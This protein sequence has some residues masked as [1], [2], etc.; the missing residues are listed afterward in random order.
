MATVAYNFK[1]IAALPAPTPPRRQQE[2]GVEGQIGLLVVTS[3]TGSKDFYLRCQVNGRRRKRKL[4]TF[5]DMG[6]KAAGDAAVLL[7]AK[8]GEGVVPVGGVQE[9]VGTYGELCEVYLQNRATGKDRLGERTLAE[10]RRILGLPELTDLRSMRPANVRS[11]D[12]A[13]AL[14]AFEE[15]DALVML[16]AVQLAISAVFTWGVV[17]HRYGLEVNPVATM[18]SR[19]EEVPRDRVL[20][21]EEMGVMWLDLEDR[22]PLFRVALRLI[23]LTG[24]RPGEVRRMRWEDIDG[25]TWT[26]PAGYRKRTKADRGRPSKAHRVHLSAPALSALDSIRGWERGGF[27]F[28]SRT[29]ICKPFDRQSLAR[30]V[31]RVVSRLGMERWTPHDLRRTAR[32]GFSEVGGAEAV[33]AEKIVGH[34]LPA[35][36]RVYDIGEQ[37]DA[38]V[39]VLDRWGEWV[40]EAVS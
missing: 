4:G 28:P 34:A 14:D 27:T 33:V 16:N 1:A 8:L 7:R 39:E 2:H 13:R 20:S 21:P 35:L 3:N 38:R 26:M 12:V 6:L 31:S 18:K 15:R 25:S 17:R 24:Q 32:T 37:W 36:L 30:T 5:P 9:E 10:R 19:Y 29:T 40:M 23:L 22:V 11:R